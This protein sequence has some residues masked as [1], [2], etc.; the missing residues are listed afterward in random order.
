[1]RKLSWMMMLTL[2]SLSL[3]VG[4]GKKDAKPDEQPT[5]NTNGEAAPESQ[6]EETT[7]TIETTE[8]STDG[9]ATEDGMIP[10]PADVG[11]VPANA[12][13]TNSGLATRVIEP[14]TGTEYPLPE[15]V[16]TVHY[17]GWTTDG[18]MFDSSVARGEPIKFPLNKVIQGWREGVMLM[19]EGETRRLWI[20]QNLAYKGAEGPPKGMLVFDVQLLKIEPPGTPIQ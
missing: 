16:V 6:P 10:P 3:A 4:C 19:V 12:E 11:A 9:E 7:E 14:G 20:P 5:E 8:E 15:S 13:T 17:T 2:L 18:K 1:M